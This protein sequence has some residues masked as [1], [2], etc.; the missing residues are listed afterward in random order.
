MAGKKAAILVA[1]VL[2]AS[3]IRAALAFAVEGPTWISAGTSF[4][5]VFPGRGT[6]VANAFKSAMGD[7]SQRT[8]F[9]FTPLNR[10]ADPCNMSGV[11]GVA[12][13]R[14]ACGQAFGSDTL[15]VTVF[16]YTSNNRFIHAGTV[17]NAQKTFGVYGGNLRPNMPD[18]R[19]VAVHEL[20]H[21]LGL[22]HET[23]PGIQSIMRPLISNIQHPQADDVAGVRYLYPAQ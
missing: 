16:S 19:R 1:L 8:P 15:A 3:P 5:Y 23:K 20:G 14:T 21:A 7:W 18:L 17:F 11:N 10:T 4:A 12:F 22:A 2:T 9:K 13:G 6:I